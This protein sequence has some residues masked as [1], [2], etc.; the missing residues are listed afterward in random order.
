M[1]CLKCNKPMERK[2]NMFFWRGEFKPGW[3]CAICKGLWPIKDEE[4]EPLKERK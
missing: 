2:E 3:V 1:I 4:I